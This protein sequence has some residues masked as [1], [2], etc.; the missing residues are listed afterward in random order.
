[1][2]RAG[3]VTHTVH[4]LSVDYVPSMLNNTTT[5]PELQRHIYRGAPCFMTQV[6]IS[7]RSKIIKQ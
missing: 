3:G 4:H 6:P 5:C 2:L 7:V 1:M